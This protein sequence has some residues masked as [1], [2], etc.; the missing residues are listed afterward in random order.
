MENK[1]KSILLLTQEL[2]K[3]YSDDLDTQVCAIFIDSINYNHLIYGY[4]VFP[5]NINISNERLIRP[6]KYKYIEHAERNGIYKAYNKGISLKDSIVIVNY[7]PCCDCTRAL[8]Q[9]EIKIVV[10]PLLLNVKNS[11][12]TDEWKISQIMFNEANI[13]IIYI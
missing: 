3:K 7:L 2:S 4:N 1:L 12:W 10:I 13:Q 5:N 6:L 8:I 11:K 9:C